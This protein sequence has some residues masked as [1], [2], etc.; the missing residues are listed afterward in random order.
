MERPRATRPGSGGRRHEAGARSR[1]RPR[2]PGR[3]RR[4]IL[5][6]SSRSQQPYRGFTRRRDVRRN[7]SGRG[8]GG[9]A[10]GWPRRV[11][12]PSALTFR[13]RSGR[14]ARADGCRRGSIGS[15]GPMTP[16]RWST[17]RARRGLPA[18]DHLPRRP[19]HPADGRALRG[20]GV[21]SCGRLRERRV[22]REPHPRPRS[23]GARTSKAISFR[24]PTRCR[25]ARP[26]TRS[27]TAWWGSSRRR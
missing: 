27:S 2:H 6:R 3:A 5:G 16:R 22:E 1:R 15:S 25:G 21:R 7:S 17:D 19:D 9:M 8:D 26:P 23:E 13:R 4:R 20:E 12:C 18:L 24:T 11:W 14:A 10:R